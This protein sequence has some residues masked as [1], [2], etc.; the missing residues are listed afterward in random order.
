M[1]LGNPLNEAIGV[2]TLD[3]LLR[4]TSDSTPAR[5]DGFIYFC[6][7]GGDGLPRWALYKATSTSAVDVNILKPK[8]SGGVDVDGDGRWILFY[9][10][11]SQAQVQALIDAIAP[12]PASLMDST[13]KALAPYLS[14]HSGV[15]AG[16]MYM[17]FGTDAS[18][19]Y[20]EIPG[21]SSPWRLWYRWQVTDGSDADWLVLKNLYEPTLT[22]DS[23]TGEP[24]ALPGSIHAE[25]YSGGTGAS[26]FMYVKTESGWESFA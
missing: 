2:E 14:E 13:N 19:I 17:Q 8:D 25:H 24:D 11:L 10:G 4:L 22:I 15:P 1:S 18:G 12:S 6:E 16:S 5:V 3:A 26:T 20:P 21:P 23:A 7:D 9:G